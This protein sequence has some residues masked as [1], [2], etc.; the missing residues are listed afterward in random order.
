MRWK[1][2]LPGLAAILVAAP[3]YAHT[4]V[5][6]HFSFESGLLHPLTGLDHLLAMF[7]V[8]LLAA[9]LGGRALWLVPGAFVGTMILGA[10][11]GF[12]GTAIPGA[13]LMILLSVIAIA[14]PVAFALGMPV[15]LAMAY[16]GLFALFHAPVYRGLRAFDGAPSCG[17]HCRWPRLRPV[18]GPGRTRA[19]SGGRSSGF[20]RIEPCGRV[21]FGHLP[22]Y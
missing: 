13:E 12:S 3:A 14:L 16:V 19:S 5:H 15:A 6:L 7:A 18:G 4:G 21:I 22:K 9:Q 2:V 11:L 1:S 17:R 20:G 8:G 10:L